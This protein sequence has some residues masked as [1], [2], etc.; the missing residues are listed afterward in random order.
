MSNVPI[1]LVRITFQDLFNLQQHWMNH[2]Q[3]LPLLYSWS[4]MSH[5]VTGA[6]KFVV[7]ERSK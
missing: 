2:N 7:R 4:F 1:A 5:H 3:P 6:T